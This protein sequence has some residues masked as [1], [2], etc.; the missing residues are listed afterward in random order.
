MNCG[1][2]SQKISTIFVDA[3]FDSKSE[4][5]CFK[6]ILYFCNNSAASLAELA[7]WFPLWEYFTTSLSI[8]GDPSGISTFEKFDRCHSIWSA[9][10]SEEV[11][12]APG[13]IQPAAE[14]VHDVAL[15]E[16]L[17][18]LQA[19]SP[20]RG[21]QEV[22]VRVEP[23]TGEVKLKLMTETRHFWLVMSTHVYLCMIVMRDEDAANT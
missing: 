4:F 2:L 12:G 15:E 10:V 18:R 17:A 22:M 7:S 21:D 14:V 1:P 23:D 6:S 11:V 16:T 8:S 9:E 3:T 13:S 19:Q 5:L 20:C